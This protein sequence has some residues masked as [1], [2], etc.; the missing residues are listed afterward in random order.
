MLLPYYQVNAFTRDAFGGNPAGVCLLEEWPPDAT[1]QRM[2]AEH[3][4][5]ETAFLVRQAAAHYD[6]RWF[7]PATEVDLCGHATLAAAHVLWHHGLEKNYELTFMTLSG[8]LH[9][10]Q[11][12]P[13]L[14][15]NFPARPPVAM[16]PPGDVAEALSAK[17]E[18]CGKARDYF[19]VLRDEAEVR[20]LQPDLER[21]AA[22]DTF[23][24]IVTARGRH[25]DFVS[26]FFAPRA[27]VP[28][29]PVTGSAHCTLIP[30]WSERLGR[31]ELSARQLS[32]R[33]GDL[34]CEAMG[35]R[36]KIAGKARTYFSGTIEL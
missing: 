31:I 8:P 24:V 15:M 13:N 5:S 36:V 3:R 22:W 25:C 16:E 23:G 17:P 11:E 2:A 21:L 26:R 30:Y 34:F 4:L 33:G 18:F 27:G 9:V 12:Y 10:T 1:L 7:T 35:D 14:A 19:F 6:L 20:E 29:D 32:A 28:E